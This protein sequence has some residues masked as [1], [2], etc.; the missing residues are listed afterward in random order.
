[1]VSNPIQVFLFL[2]QPIFFR[3]YFLIF[4]YFFLIF[5]YFLYFFFFFLIFFF[6]FFYFFSGV[7]P[8]LR[9]SGRLD[10][11]I[12]VAPPTYQTRIQL[13]KYFTNKI[14]KINENINFE[15][16]AKISNGTKK[17]KENIFNF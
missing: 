13:F 14:Q 5:Y 8:A 3:V 4:F 12:Y 10:R 7:D 11:A 9:R 16:L 1:M 17:K 15:N 6:N 2:V